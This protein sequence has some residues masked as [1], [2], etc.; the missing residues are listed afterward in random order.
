MANNDQ[1]LEELIEAI[2]IVNTAPEY[3]AILKRNGHK[4][5]RGLPSLDYYDNKID[6]VFDRVKFNK[7]YK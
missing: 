2:K 7:Y 1:Q 3:P 6:P 4:W 5:N